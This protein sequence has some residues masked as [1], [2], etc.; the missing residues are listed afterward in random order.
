MMAEEDPIALARVTRRRR[1]KVDLSNKK[2]QDEQSEKIERDNGERVK[3]ASSSESNDS[4][5]GR[6]LG[7]GTGLLTDDYYLHPYR[8]TRTSVNKEVI[9]AL[10]RISI[11][12]L[13]Y[14]KT[15]LIDKL[16]VIY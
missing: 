2:S 13:V 15:E 14:Y 11:I 3:S 5:A 16:M 12:L 6:S 10:I 8:H 4:G 7:S 9:V 1:N